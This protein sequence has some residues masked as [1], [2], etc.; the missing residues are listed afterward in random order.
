MDSHEEAEH[1]AV[2]EAREEAGL[3]PDRI[4]VVTAV[5]T[6][7]VL[8]IHGARWTYTTV[9]A[10]ASELLMTVPNRESAELR[11]VPEVLVTELPLHPAFAKS[12]DRLRTTSR[13][14]AHDCGGEQP[15]TVVID[16]ESFGWC[17]PR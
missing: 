7:E 6:A 17:A 12:W 11:W 10:D 8:A 2:R 14:P 9:V 1:A 15:H 5:V 3:A 4:A 13:V 16:D